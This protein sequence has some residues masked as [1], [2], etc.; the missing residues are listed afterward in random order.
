MG[1][2]FYPGGSGKRISKHDN[3]LI[4]SNLPPCAD[5]ERA[6][7][8]VC[9]GGRRDVSARIMIDRDFKPCNSHLTLGAAQAHAALTGIQL[10]ARRFLNGLASR[11]GASNTLLQGDAADDN[12]DDYNNNDHGPRRRLRC[13]LHRIL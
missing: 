13:L 1:G 2:A 12:D 8:N 5:M 3:M 7:W 6:Y 10:A 11:D 9:D 4:M